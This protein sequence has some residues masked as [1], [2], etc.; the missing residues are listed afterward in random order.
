MQKPGI[1]Y[2]KTFRPVARFD[3]IRTVLSVA[4]SRKLELAQFDVKMAFLYGELE[5]D[6]S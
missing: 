5:E 3:T 2:D 6:Y 4:A 1:D